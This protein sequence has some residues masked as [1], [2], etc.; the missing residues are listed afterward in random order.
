MQFG[1]VM[2]LRGVP[3]KELF[4]DVGYWQ[5]TRVPWL[6]NPLRAQIRAIVEKH[7]RYF[8]YYFEGMLLRWTPRITFQSNQ[9]GRA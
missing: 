1:F 4:K 5:R 9:K 2:A 8:K 6:G 7:V 3:V